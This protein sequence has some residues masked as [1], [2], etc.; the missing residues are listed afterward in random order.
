MSGHELATTP[1]GS[2]R[3]EAPEGSVVSAT[4]GSP[5]AALPSSAS[6]ASLAAR[7]ESEEKQLAPPALPPPAMPASLFGVALAE[8]PME[9]VAGYPH[10]LPLVL[11]MLGR[12]LRTSGGL[13]KEGVFRVSAAQASVE[14]ARK[15]VDTE[16]VLPP[17]D[18]AAYVAANLISAFFREL[19]T[20]LLSPL[21]PAEVVVCQDTNAAAALLQKLPPLQLA[22][23]QW[24]LDLA[25]DLHERVERT[26]MGAKNFAV[27]MAPSLFPVPT[28]D[29]DD[30]GYRS[31]LFIKQSLMFLELAALFR[32]AQRQQLQSQTP[33]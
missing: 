9:A 32:R 16:G 12:A 26:R 22:V 29:G 4:S 28:M 6:A 25:V 30:A 1:G 10:P 33:G 2:P 24:L 8:S 19:P 23:F 7:S 13:E 3:Q 20:P 11:V 17:S 15:S 5:P 18:D 21:D 31:M 27:V 14:A